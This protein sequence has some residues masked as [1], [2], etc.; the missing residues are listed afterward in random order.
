MHYLVTGGCGYIGSI[1]ASL[2][3]EQKEVQVT[4]IDNLLNNDAS[5]ADTLKAMYPGRVH[6][7][8]VDVRNADSLRQVFSSAQ[9]DGVLHFA[10]LKSVSESQIDPLSYY[11][12]NFVG[13]MTLCRVMAEFDVFSLVFSSS[14][15]VYGIPEVDAPLPETAATAPITPY[16]RSKLYCEQFFADLAKSDPRWAIAILRYFNPIGAH[17]SGLLGE[18]PTTKPNN[19]MPIIME[20]A[21]GL[22]ASVDVYGGDYPT[23][24]GTGVRDYIHVMDLAEGHLAALTYIKKVKGV[25]VFNLGCGRG[26]SVMQLLVA[27]TENTGISIP[28]R[29]VEPRQGD[30]ASVCADANKA[31]RLLYWSARFD[32]QDMVTDHWNW[33]QKTMLGIN[34]AG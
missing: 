24:D 5:A 7:E 20:V 8:Q 33:S 27:V 15:T 29:I 2:L 11:E 34:K 14:A 12:N 10:G 6:F 13:T 4:L 32:L 18:N 21:N 23:H 26:Y 28:H 31:R 17:P 22:R 19:L 9:F 1:T 30:A 16:G 25:D 3:C